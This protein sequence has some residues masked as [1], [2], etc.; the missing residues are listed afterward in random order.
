MGASS[1][2]G[3]PLGG[4]PLRGHPLGGLIRPVV[5]H[6][7]HV[8]DHDLYEERH[9][10]ALVHLPCSLMAEWARPLQT[11]RL[12]LI[13]NHLPVYPSPIRG[14]VSFPSSSEHSVLAYD[15]HWPAPFVHGLVLHVLP[16]VSS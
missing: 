14:F 4:H 13:S 16:P 12:D 2:E 15:R 8:L 1:G 10:H 9:D 11:G 5:D 7:D 6:H 3:H